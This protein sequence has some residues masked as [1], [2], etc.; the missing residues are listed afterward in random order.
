LERQS[1]AAVASLRREVDVIGIKLW[2]IHYKKY[3]GN[4]QMRSTD[5]KELH[6]DQASSL[7]R[8]DWCLEKLAITKEILKEIH[9][10]N[11]LAM[12]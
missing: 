2:F 9:S 4:D 6:K 12:G 5:T 1:V 11:T 3:A 7:Y 10:S 8:E